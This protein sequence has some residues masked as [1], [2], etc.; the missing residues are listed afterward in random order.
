M[1]ISGIGTAAEAA[2][3]IIGCPGPGFSGHEFGVKLCLEK[4]LS[5]AEGLDG[6]QGCTGVAGRS[7]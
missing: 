7:A 6:G 1:D 2:K 4:E 5:N 3:G